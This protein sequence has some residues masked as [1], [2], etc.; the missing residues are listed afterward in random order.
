MSKISNEKLSHEDYYIGNM[1]RMQKAHYLLQ[2][3]ILG[4]KQVCIV[5]RHPPTSL[6]LMSNPTRASNPTPPTYP[7]KPL[8]GAGL[9]NL[10][11]RSLLSTIVL[12]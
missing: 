2:Y 4:L 8:I 11:Y 9:T 12:A 3:N 10:R 5:L 6:I 1:D 7:F